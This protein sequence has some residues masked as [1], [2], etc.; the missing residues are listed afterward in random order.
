MERNAQRK[1]V[2]LVL[3]ISLLGL[4][5]AYKAEQVHRQLRSDS[6]FTSFCNVN[7]V[8]NCDVVLS[9]RW[10]EFAG[11]SVSLLATAFYTSLSLLAAAM[12][13]TDG[14]AVRRRMAGGLVAAATFGIGFSA[15]MAVIAFG[16]LRAVCILCT[17]L[18]FIAL[19]NFFA[20]WR[21]YRALQVASRVEKIAALRKDQWLYSGLALAAAVVLVA[22]LWE[23]AR[24]WRE[25]TSGE[26]VA[27]A[28]PR[29]AEWFRNL[30]IVDVP[31]DD[32]NS[33]GPTDALVTI[34]EFSDFECA[35]CASLHKALQETWLRSPGQ[36]RIVFR[37]FPLD[38]A[39]N[40][41]VQSRFHALACEAAFAA[42]CAGQ[43]G[44]FWP[45]HDLLFD[46]QKTLSPERFREIAREI[47]L[48]LSS[49]ERCMQ[50]PGTRQ[51]VESD[52][53][54]GIRLGVN[55]TPTMFLNGRAIRGALDAETLH[56]AF[57]LGQ[58][59]DRVR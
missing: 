3:A 16:V 52:V 35:H 8:V 40:P 9:S 58:A 38:S 31:V 1:R 50:D 21:T 47:G 44:K 34:V 36:I 23:T 22:V 6:A 20:A 43:Q 48:D 10:S 26:E 41:L 12:L 18:Y 49:F 7:R 39:C 15:Y 53:A 46:H 14:V 32:R 29:L 51:R 56:R 59:T 28:D 13:F 45:Y 11:I 37:H 19:L 17:A 24:L 54:L 4:W 42:E 55:S 33:R 57:L 2:L 25:P 5:V 30:A 27:Q